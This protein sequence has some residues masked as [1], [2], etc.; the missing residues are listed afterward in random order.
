MKQ[1]KRKSLENFCEAAELGNAAAQLNLAWA[2]EL[3]IAVEKDV[4][5]AAEWYRKA[6]EQGIAA[7]QLG[8]AETKKK[9]SCGWQKRRNADFRELRTASL[10]AMGRESV[11]KRT[12][13]RQL[14]SKSRRARQR[15]GAIQSRT[16]LPSRTGR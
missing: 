16:S 5:K 1:D 9:P 11:A 12:T 15:S 10:P 6:A 7:A 8:L 4:E 14:V 2:F 3:G 13:R